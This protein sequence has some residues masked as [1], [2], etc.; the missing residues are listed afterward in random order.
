LEIPDFVEEKVGVC[1]EDGV[2]DTDAVDVD[3]GFDFVR[4]RWVNVSDFVVVPVSEVDRVPVVVCVPVGDALTKGVALVVRGVLQ[5]SLAVM[6]P[7]GVEE[8]VLVLET[9]VELGVNVDEDVL[10][11]VALPVIDRGGVTDVV[12][13]VVVDDERVFVSALDKEAERDTLDDG[14]TDSVIVA[15]FV[16]ENV[17][18][19][20]DDDERVKVNDGEALTVLVLDC[21]SDCVTV[22]VMVLDVVDVPDAVA[23][24]VVE[25][26]EGDR[27]WDRVME[28]LEV[29]VSVKV[30]VEVRL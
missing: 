30:Y 5:L 8:R 26:T 28:L 15:E 13:D 14:D 27:E 12:D 17:R 11:L 7:D 16:E 19:S 9:R 18:E 20:V 25:R 6:K 10:I 23:V 3:V 24:R 22:T 2:R 1:V 21:D 4:D 29:D